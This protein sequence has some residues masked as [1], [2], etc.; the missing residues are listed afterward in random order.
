MTNSLHKNCS[1][2]P[3]DPDTLLRVEGQVGGDNVLDPEITP[4]RQRFAAPAAA[5]EAVD[6]Q[7]HRPQT[8]QSGSGRRR[9]SRHCIASASRTSRRPPRLSPTPHSSFIAS[10][11]CRLP[12]TPT[13]VAQQARPLAR[14]ALTVDAVLGRDYPTI[15]AVI[16]V[17]SFVYVF[18]NLIVDL[19]YCLLDP[20]I[21]YE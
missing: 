21:R 4:Q 15:Q 10:S 3:Y 11:A 19:V 2:Y 13:S 20:R 9:N 17:L 14:S 7:D 6:E 8:G 12:I 5:A 18:I 16:L 1:R